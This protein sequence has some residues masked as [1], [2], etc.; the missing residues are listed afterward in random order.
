MIYYA[1][2]DLARIKR[3]PILYDPLNNRIHNAIIVTMIPFTMCQGRVI[4]E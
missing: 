3:F 2:R 4:K 1:I